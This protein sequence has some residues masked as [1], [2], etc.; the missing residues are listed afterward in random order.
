MIEQF[1]EE[2]RDLERTI[3]IKKDELKK[4][5]EAALFEKP[6][7]LVLVEMRDQFCGITD[8]LLIDDTEQAIQ[9]I[10]NEYTKNFMYSYRVYI[11]RVK[12]K[13]QLKE[14]YTELKNMKDL[15][16]Y[17]EESLYQ[18]MDENKDKLINEDA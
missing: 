4:M 10:E 2:I 17:G 6:K 16:H 11:Y 3:E 12:D 1:K 7:L 18:W 13:N 9:E 14:D 8:I 15:G 5:M